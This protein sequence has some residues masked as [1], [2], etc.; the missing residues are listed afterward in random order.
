VYISNTDEIVKGFKKKKTAQKISAQLLKKNGFLKL[1]HEYAL[2]GLL[3]F[4][5]LDCDEVDPRLDIF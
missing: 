5:S 2:H 1:L 3:A 4:V